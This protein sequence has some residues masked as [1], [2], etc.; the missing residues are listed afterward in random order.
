VRCAVPLLLLLALP[1]GS[2]RAAEP[3]LACP[4]GTV[5]RTSGRDGGCETPGGVAEG[6]FWSRAANGGL[7][8]VAHAHLGRPHGLWTSFHSNGTRATEAEYVDGELCGAFRRWDADGHLLYE[9][10]HDAHGE[11]DGV[12]THYWPNGH[13]RA[14]WTMAHGRQEGPVQIW[15]ES[16]TPKLRGR[17]HDGRADGEFTWW[18]ESGAV[19][20]RCRVADGHPLEGA[21]GPIP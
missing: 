2:A 18:D 20:N 9:G 19:V 14:E 4:P 11:M 10:R 3:S 6:P 12:W 13:K 16:G 5:L 17:R 21:C 8:Y 15:Y 1:A 7:R